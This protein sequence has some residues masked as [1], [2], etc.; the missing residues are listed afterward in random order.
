MAR[1][2]RILNFI[3]NLLLQEDSSLLARAA[4]SAG[5]MLPRYPPQIAS[6]AVT[7][8]PEAYEQ[9]L[10]QGLLKLRLNVIRYGT[11]FTELFLRS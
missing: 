8:S 6:L 11:L 3:G 10:A 1:I 9:A 2:V 5:Q 7:D 4:I